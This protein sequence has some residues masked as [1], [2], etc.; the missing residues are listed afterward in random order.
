M[1]YAQNPYAPPQAPPPRLE[2]AYGATQPQEWTPGEVL[3][4]AWERFKGNWGVLVLSFFVTFVIVEALAIGPAALQLTREMDPGTLTLVQIMMNVM[5][6]SVS[7]YLQVGLT[8]IWL[9]AARGGTPSFD[10]LFSGFDRLLPYLA[11]SLLMVIAVLIGTICFIIP[12]VLVGLGLVLSQFYVVDARMGP[13]SALS[14]SWKATSGQRQKV[15]ILTFAVGLLCVAGL[16]TCGI[17][18]FVAVPVGNM[19]LAIAFLR[20]SGRERAQSY[21]P[22]APIPA[23]YGP[24]F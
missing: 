23:G 14:A 15:F 2:D 8:R 6:M 22:S 17:G 3:G 10:L 20:M 13:I 1:N 5:Q 7:L 21:A 19:A 4:L 24:G 9:Q 16:L 18:A 12:G 11:S